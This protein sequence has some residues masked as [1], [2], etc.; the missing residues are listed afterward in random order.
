MSPADVQKSSY[1]RKSQHYHIFRTYLSFHFLNNNIALKTVFEGKGGEGFPMESS[2]QYV[3][4]YMII[5]LYS[6]FQRLDVAKVK[7]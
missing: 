2:P 7:T 6:S 4:S 3:S 5:Y 1:A